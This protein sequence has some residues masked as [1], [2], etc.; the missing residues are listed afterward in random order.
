MAATVKEP[1]ELDLMREAGRIVARG[2][3]LLQKNLR[4]GMSTGELDAMFE[5]H[6]R[7][8]G[9]V[10]TFKGYRG[11]PASL[12]VS[13]NEE[14]VH[15]IPSPDRVV[16]D[17][18]LVSLDAGATYK[19]YVGDSAVTVGVGKVPERAKRLM[20]VGREC[21][22]K[23]IAAVGPGARL[24]E[25]AR[26]VQTHAEGSGYSVVKKYVGHGIG[27]KLHEDPQVPNYVIH[28]IE[29]FEFILRPGHAIAIEPMV[30]EG[31]D[32]VRTLADDWTVI[33]K[34]RKLS[35][36]FEHTIAVTASGREILTL[37]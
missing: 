2:L 23:A 11:F 27:Q 21:L 17:G 28:P 13:I 16:K 24:S 32:D 37:P 22:E 5:K 31:T 6:V 7:A 25:I 30:N 36:H 33:T 29:S 1:W 10:P 18:D 20:Q 3:Q 9:A 4:P 8:S 14:V 15:G 35:V 34:D 26:A 19:G 12:C